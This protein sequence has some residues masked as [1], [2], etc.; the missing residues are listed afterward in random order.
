MPLVRTCAA[1]VGCLVL[2]VL[3]V[4]CVRVGAV[5]S[6]VTHDVQCGP[7]DTACEC[8][9]GADVC[10]FQFYVENVYTFTRYNSS[11]PYAQGQGELFYINEEGEL[12]SYRHEGV[13]LEGNFVKYTAYGYNGTVQ[14]YCVPEAETIVC[15]N[16]NELCTDPITV[17]GMT[18]K[19]VIAVN[20]QF[21]GPTLIVRE[22]QTVV[23]DVHNNLSTE[24]IS[25]HWH[26]QHQLQTNYMDGVGLV[27]QCPIQPGSS[28]R[29]IFRANPSGTFWYHSHM[30]SQRSNGLFGA[31]IVKE[32]QLTYP[33]SFV[34]EPALHTVTVMDWYRDDFESFFRR[35]RFGIG[36]YPDL[37]FFTVPSPPIEP[38]RDTVGPDHA[39]IGNIPFWAG[40]IHGMGRH[41]SVPYERSR[42]KI[43]EVRELG[44]YRF[45][46]IHTGVHYAF[47]FS[48]EGHKL[49]VI[50]ADGYLVEPLEVDYIALH[51]GERYDF[52]LEANHEGSDYWMKAETFEV[53][54][55]ASTTPPYNFLNHSAEAILH[56]SGG[57]KPR[58]SRYSSIPRYPKDCTGDAPCK[59]L[60]CPLGNFH[61][62]YNIQCIS[63]DDLKLFSPTPEREMPNETPDIT[64][65]MNMGG[66][67]VSEKPISSIND[68]NFRFPSYPLTTHYEKNPEDS[69]CSVDSECDRDGGCECTTVMDLDYNVTVRVVLS[70]V[71]MERNATHSMHIHG[72]SVHVLEVGHGKYDY[73]NGAL[74]ASSRD[75]TCT[76]IGDDYDSLDHH[77]CPNPRF[78]DPYL[79]F[80]LDHFTVRK[81]TVT[82]PSGGYV[83][84]QFHSDNPGFWF[85]HCHVELHQLEGMVLVIREA[86]DKIHTPPK[87][88]E[89]CGTFLWDI[90]AFN[91]ASGTGSSLM[92]VSH[93]S[94]VVVLTIFVN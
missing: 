12:V 32:K 28:F 75:L 92:L 19:T 8:D 44:T 80:P 59:M 34:D 25:I 83:V 60:N 73:E 71:G 93:I 29:Y 6:Q 13:C 72:H 52:L 1:P 69:F 63:V 70:A 30:G 91:I 21:P 17:D 46:L 24:G 76:D 67:V 9:A 3:C 15:I 10:R 57:E 54:F 33:I 61:F 37:P 31:L 41:P 62:S 50:A 40:L 77:R 2:V 27:T 38:Y 11:R 20:K 58:P 56:Y 86:V 87:E 81:D 4:L 82:V 14:T 45:R 66:F 89:T 23:V 49:K 16:K 51:S 18:F 65:F 7:I 26:G 36:S 68:K 39:E 42:L 35:E 78:R 84:V 55:D 79:V 47:K 64:Y 22:G 88:M 74:V 5:H 90:A 48:I 53:D 43:Y 94:T 85:L